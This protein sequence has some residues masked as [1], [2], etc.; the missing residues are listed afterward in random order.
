MFTLIGS[1]DHTVT[2]FLFGIIPHNQSF[3]SFFSFFSFYGISVL[4]W[5]ILAALLII[6]EEKRDRKFIV[7]LALSL[8]L[9]FFLT[10]IVFKNVF[11]RQRPI[12]TIVKSLSIC[13]KDYSFPSGHASVAFAG[14][15]ILA[16]F[17]KK[18][19]LG[20]YAIAVII[21][22]SRIYLGCH[23]FIDVVGGSILGYVISITVLFLK[24]KTRNRL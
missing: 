21:A 4:V 9:T 18:R 13:P 7:Y 15:A 12:N 1:I 20:Y 14:A 23:F 2:N 3:D 19:R 16:T 5:V 22:Y 8:F 17:D 6:F 10:N 11:H 24:E